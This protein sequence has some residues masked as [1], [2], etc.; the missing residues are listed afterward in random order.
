MPLSITDKDKLLRL[1]QTFDRNYRLTKIY[2]EYLTRFPE[3][4]C[5]E[6]IAALTEDGSVDT[7]Y[8][9]SAIIAEAFALDLECSGEDRRLFRDYI[10]PSVRTLDGQKYYSDPYWRRMADIS[11]RLGKWEIKTEEYPAYRAVVC[12]DIIIGSDFSEIVPLGFFPEKFNFLAVLE[13]DNEWM[14]LTPVDL[15]TCREAIDAAHGRVI[16]FGL[17]LGYYTY[18]VSEKDEVECVTVVEI[19]DEAISLFK[20]NILPRFSHPEKVRVIKADAFRFAEEEMPK[21]HYDVAF[22][23]TWRDASDGAP[24]YLKMKKCEKLNTGTHFIYWIENFLISRLR[25]LRFEEIW[26]AYE[27]GRLSDMPESYEA[28]CRELTPEALAEHEFE[29]IK[30]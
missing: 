6:M 22:V 19:S 30:L 24:M 18:M 25:S 7:P 11:E 2:S 17:G 10:I 27:D 29:E 8:A 15:D 9:I 26:R 3:L 4:I 20:K 28:I 12:D 1:R 23:D 5:E 16:T 13:G 14:T 21:E